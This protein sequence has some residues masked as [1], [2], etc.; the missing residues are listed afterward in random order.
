MKTKF[1]FVGFRHPHIEQMVRHC[2]ERSDVEVV[3]CCE[4]DEAARQAINEKGDLQISHTRFEHVLNDVD[5]DVIAIGDCFGRRGQLAIQSLEAGKHVISDKPICTSRV[6]LDGIESIAQAR[7]LLVSCMLDMRD[8]PPF[9][10]LRQTIQA[11]EIGTVRAI[12]FDGQH[13]LLLGRRASWYFEP[14]MHG[15]TL[16][17]IAIHAMDMIPWA[18]G[19]QI[20]SIVA[21]RCWNARLPEYPHFQ[22]CGQAMLK[23]ENGAGVLCDVSYLSPDSFGY[24]M[25]L[26]WQF[27]FWG[28]RGV[29]SAGVNQPTI[30]LYQNGETKPHELPL[31]AALPGAYLDAFLRELSGQREGLHLSSAEAIRAARISLLL[32]EAADQSLT[33]IEI[34]T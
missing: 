20:Q 26:Y 13:P 21:A 3:A 8:L 1:A 17:D 33:H 28:D 29:L 19:L 24:V 22:E 23:L 9:L 18:T 11:G 10:G 31:P 16:N 32:Q 15:G 4:E 25:P 2:R 14:D 34:R 30:T 27:T 7:K 6:E 12:R 5:C